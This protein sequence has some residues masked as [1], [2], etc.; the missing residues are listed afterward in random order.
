MKKIIL[1]EIDDDDFDYL[2]DRLIDLFN[3]LPLKNI[4]YIKE[5]Y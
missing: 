5:G 4:P 3:I 2:K 1:M